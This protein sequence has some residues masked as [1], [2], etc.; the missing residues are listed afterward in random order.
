[1]QEQ[2]FIYEDFDTQSGDDRNMRRRQ[3]PQ[4]GFGHRPIRWRRW[5]IIALIIMFL[6]VWPAWAGFYTDWLWFNEVG[7]QSIF[8]TIL[9]TQV[10]SALIGGLMAALLFWLSLK[11]ALRV[12]GKTGEAGYRFYVANQEIAIAD[13]GNLIARLALPISLVIGAFFGLKSWSE[14]DEFLLFRH[15]ASFGEK[16]PVLGFDISFYL[17]KLPWLDFVSGSLLTL[18]VF[19]TLA[20]IVV[21]LGRAAL[22]LKMGDEH[23]KPRLSVQRG[24]RGHL[25]ALLAGIFIVIAFRY[26][27]DL[28]GL[29]T[30][31]S[32]TVTGAGYT[33]INATLPILW[34]QIGAALLVAVMA[35]ASIFL[36]HLRLVFLGGLLFVLVTVAGIIYPALVQRFSVAPNELQK[37]SPYLAYSIAATRKAYN[38]ENVEERDLTGEATLTAQDIQSNRRTINSIRLWDQGPLLS[39]FAQLQEIRPYYEFQNVD[40]DRYKINGEVQQVMLS[41]RELESEKLPN[42]N[43]INERLIFTHGYGLTLGPVNQITA[44]GLPMLYVKDIPPVSIIPTLKIERPEIYFGEMENEHVFVRTRQQ[45]FNFPEGE[46]NQFTTYTG[47]GGVSI[48]S[49][50]RKLLFSTRLGE[51]KLMLSDDITAES[52]V[53]YH[54]NIKERL[55]KIAPYLM[56]DHDPYLVISEGKCFWICDAYTTSSRYPYSSSIRLNT[57]TDINYIRNSVKAVVDAYNGTVQLY[58]ADDRDPMIQTYARIFPGVLKPLSEM[59]PDLKTHLR[60]PEDIFSIQTRVY[61]TYHMDQPQVFYNK[62]DQWEI[63]SAAESDGQSTAMEPYYTIMKLPDAPSEEFLVMLPFVPKNKLNLSA[64]MVARSDGENYGKMVVYRIPKHK[65]IYGPKQIVG[66]INADTEISGQLTLWSQRGSKVIFGTMLVIPINGSLLYVQPLY[67]Q[68]ETGKIPELKRVIVVNENKI[69]MGENL[70]QSLTKLF[71]SG[72]A[73]ALPP[74]GE[75]MAKAAQ[76]SAPTTPQRGLAAQAM[77]HYDRAEQALKEGD[78][79][80]YGEELKK[81]RTVLED[82]NK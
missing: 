26:Y 7:Y 22:S 1:M 77:Q 33:D 18:L 55:G 19:A 21:Y 28:P 15:G 70:E 44:E 45:E 14:W 61:A 6:I 2:D 10:L 79:A 56:F 17:F 50:F 38:L 24:A 72:T 47:T 71:G 54:R 81:L 34:A 37:E 52:R 41:V 74:E 58:I 75:T 3:I 67:L 46:K 39:T 30:S 35:V 59:S 53:L 8:T 76:P 73:P 23:E 32:G 63:A 82:L 64:W 27:L 60:Y 66:R 12:S 36:A 42:R 80:K 43:W 5:A 31:N 16:D 11:V 65:Q 49:Y 57:Q 29:L 78:W 20:A 51:L 62:E 69:V 40:N 9:V 4:G 25:L 68:A 48:G 13:A